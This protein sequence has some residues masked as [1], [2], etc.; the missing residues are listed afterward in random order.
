MRGPVP[1]A[2]GSH[3]VREGGAVRVGPLLQLPITSSSCLCLTVPLSL[4]L[5]PL[6][7]KTNQY[8]FLIFCFI[9]YLFIYCIFIIP[10]L[11]YASECYVLG[12]CQLLSHSFGGEKRGGSVW[13]VQLFVASSTQKR[14]RERER[15]L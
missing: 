13:L 3:G 4:V 6:S 9:I 5:L 11:C 14:E 15:E 1:P 7:N 12:L 10:M 8:Y 2:C